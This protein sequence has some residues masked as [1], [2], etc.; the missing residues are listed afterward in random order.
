MLRGHLKLPL[1]GLQGRFASGGYGNE[2]LAVKSVFLSIYAG[3]GG[4]HALPCYN[5]DLSQ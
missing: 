1:H 3:K 4:H 5:I 2:W